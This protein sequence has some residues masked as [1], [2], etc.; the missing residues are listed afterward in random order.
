[1]NVVIKESQGQTSPKGNRGDQG[2]AGPMGPKGPAGNECIF[3]F[4][5]SEAVAKNDYIDLGNSSNNSLR[6]TL[7]VPY[8]CLVHNIAFN[9]RKL[10][11]PEPYIV[12]LYVN[13]V[14]TSATVV[15]PDGSLDFKILST[16]FYQ[17]NPLDLRFNYF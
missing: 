9:I 3:L 7:V 17:L 12:T 11:N 13:N 2:P 1:V 16:V 10:A 5:S 4:A 15:I 14:A 8:K 6:N